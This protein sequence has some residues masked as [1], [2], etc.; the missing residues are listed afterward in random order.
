MKMYSFFKKKLKERKK[1]GKKGCHPVEEGVI[2]SFIQEKMQAEICFTVL[3]WLGIFFFLI[4]RRVFLVTS[5]AKRVRCAFK[6][7]SASPNFALVVA[8]RLRRAGKC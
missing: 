1:G 2:P 3:T 6:E 7:R 5:G 4:T 8:H